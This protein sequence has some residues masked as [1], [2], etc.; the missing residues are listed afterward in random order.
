MRVAAEHC[1]RF[2]FVIYFADTEYIASRFVGY[3]EA[4]ILFYSF[5]F[6]FYFI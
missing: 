5:Q 6:V 2:H 4:K 1:S 3:E